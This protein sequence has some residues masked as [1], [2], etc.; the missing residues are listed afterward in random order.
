MMR[1]LVFL[2]ANTSYSHSMLSYAMIRSFNA[3]KVPDWQWRE[4]ETVTVADPMKTAIELSD[5]NPDIL[6]ATAYLFN[7]DFLL[8][9]IARFKQ[10]QPE[11]PVF[12]GGPE[13][14]G[15]NR[16]FLQAHS[17]ISGVIRGDESS[18]WQVLENLDT[19]EQQRKIPGMCLIDADCHYHD[20]GAAWFDG[21]L[22]EMPTPYQRDLLPPGKSFVQLETSRGCTG[23]C[24]FCAGPTGHLVKH[25]SLERV[26]SDLRNIRD[27]GFKEVRILDRTFN[28][29]TTRFEQLINLFKDEFPD[30]N[31]H[32]EINPARLDGDQIA[33]LMKLPDNLLH[34]EAGVQSL[35]DKVLHAVKRPATVTRTMGGL[36]ALCQLDNFEVH[37]DLI[38]GLPQ[39]DLAGVIRDVIELVVLGPEEIQLETLKV[40]PG[41]PLREHL[42]DQMVYSP[43][44]PYEVLRTGH[45]SSEDLMTARQ[46]SN[47]LESYY[48]TPVLRP[49]FRFAVLQRE[50]FLLRFLETASKRFS[51]FAARPAMTA[52]FNTLE[53]YA[54][55]DSCLLELIKFAHLATAGSPAKY[56]LKL[57]KSQ[58]EMFDKTIDA[59]FPK[60]YC[61][62]DFAWNVDEIYR[63]QICRPEMKICR[64]RFFRYQSGHPGE[65]RKV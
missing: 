20:N 18:V 24:T 61:E 49:V 60:R 54:A 39:Q 59:S 44:P 34:V 30:M 55:D 51:D 47:L 22:D 63:D 11:V 56:D 40:L 29:N 16:L 10:L 28:G 46:I 21:E 45:L 32:L 6:V 41:T 19:P 3:E 35:D 13:F 26:K 43:D 36:N 14:L 15:D 8:R 25:H 1:N 50:N 31:F 42:P 58:P 4:Y 33:L 27:A 17:C 5:M 23:G 62:A 38:A 37:A 57:H 52:R 12:L 65:Y 64:F 7:I 2:G 53:E 48:N 9:V